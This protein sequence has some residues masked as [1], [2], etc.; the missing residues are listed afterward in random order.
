MLRRA[1]ATLF[2]LFLSHGAY[3]AEVRIAVPKIICRTLS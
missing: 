3:A 1:L 2:I